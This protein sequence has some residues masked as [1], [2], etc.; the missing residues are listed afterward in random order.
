M[1][2]AEIGI[3]VT[4]GFVPA[5]GVTLHVARAGPEDGPLVILLHG[6]PEFWYGWRRQIPTLAAAGY[7]VWAPDQR[8]Y[9]LSDKPE[10]IGD[11][12]VSRLVEDVIARIAAAGRR[13]AVLVGHDWGAVVAWATAMAHPERVAR[14]AVLNAPHPTVMARAMRNGWSQRRKSR[15]MAFFQLPRVPEWLLGRDGFRPARRALVASGLPGTFDQEDLD[16]YREAWSQPGAPRAM[17]DWYRAAFR[18]PPRAV[19]RP[20]TVTLRVPMSTLI[21]WG[22][23]DVFLGRELAAPSLEFCMQG[24]L[25]FVDASHWLQHDRSAEVNALL[26]EF[27]AAG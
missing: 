26:L 22:E 15:Y 14:L 5:A 10:Q 6:F 1:N 27:L 23:H 20:R 25:H 7:R 16:R 4:F 24:K 9:N 13:D 17:L 18:R 8:G 21:L 11:Y 12:R 3:G 2:R 19:A